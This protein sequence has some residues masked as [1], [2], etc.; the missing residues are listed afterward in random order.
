MRELRESDDDFLF[1][2]ALPSMLIVASYTTALDLIVHLRPHTQVMPKHCFFDGTVTWLKNRLLDYLH[3]HV[4][5]LLE[6][7]FIV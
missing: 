1:A 7:T 2:G 4:F 6:T 3:F 5:D